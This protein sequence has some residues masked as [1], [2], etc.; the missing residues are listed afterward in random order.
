MGRVFAWTAFFEALTWA[1]LLLT[2]VLVWAALPQG[3]FWGAGFMRNEP[4]F[5]YGPTA[6]TIGNSG[7]GGSCAFADPARDVSAADV[8]TR[9]SPHLIGDPRALRLLDALYA[10]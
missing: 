8:M 5:F 6:T 7:W 2:A 4:N 1:G 3:L 9:Q 10:A